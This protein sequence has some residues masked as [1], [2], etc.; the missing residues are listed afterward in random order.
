MNYKV[1]DSLTAERNLYSALYDSEDAHDIENDEKEPQTFN[2]AWNHE[3][4]KERIG[5]RQAIRK[6]FTDMKARNVWRKLKKS[7]VPRH[8]RTIGCT[9]IFK[10]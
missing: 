7:D 4:S 3:S 8:K 5:W 6:E 2:E 10:S 9:W 1:T